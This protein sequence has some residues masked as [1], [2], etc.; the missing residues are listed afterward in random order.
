MKISKEE[1]IGSILFER[2]R[3]KYISPIEIVRMLT[4]NSRKIQVGIL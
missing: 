1:I 3:V 4:M 2:F